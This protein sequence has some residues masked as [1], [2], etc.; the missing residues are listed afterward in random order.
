MV[1]TAAH[2]APVSAEF[3]RARRLYVGYSG[4]LDSHVLLHALVALRGPLGITALH[5]NHQ[6]S[7]HA[8]TW[9]GHCRQTCADLGVAYVEEAVTVVAQ[10][11][12]LENAAR[13]LRYAVFERYVGEGDLLLLGHH[14]DDQS[15]TV[16]F[17]LLRA[18]GPGGLAGIPAARSLRAGALLRPLLGVTRAALRHYASEQGLRWIE[19]ESNQRL[20]FD[21]NYIR[22]QVVPVLAARWPDY[23][24]RLTQSAARC[25]DAASLLRD[26]GD[27]DLRVLDERAERLGWS[28]DVRGLAA[29]SDRRRDN[30]LRH[31]SVLKGLAPPGRGPLAAVSAELLGARRDASPLVCWH[32]GEWRRFRDRLYLVPGRRW[33]TRAIT[34]LHWTSFPQP[35]RLADGSVIEAF[36]SHGAGLRVGAGQRLAIGVRAG[37]ERCRP[38]GRSG[39]NTLKKLLQ[40]QGLEPWL[41]D[42]VPLIYIDG[43][44]AAVGDLWLCAGFCDPAGGWALRWQ[45]PTA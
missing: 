18:A 22:H 27:L 34:P 29:L 4:G 44:L 25:G 12:G 23:A 14:A 28:L 21:R 41:R 19:D 1:F 16:L 42:Y 33:R 39:S 43:E 10:G 9:A 17:R 38:A 30:V 26:L 11:D 35:L 20:E 15:E 6:L 2:L 3:N 7:L 5:I 31:W 24:A 40:A 37:G 8:Q 13:Q 36:K 32:D 45:F